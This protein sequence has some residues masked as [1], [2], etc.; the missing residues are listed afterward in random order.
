[1]T[2]APGKMDIRS[3]RLPDLKRIMTESREE[4][5]RAV[6][7]FD[8][9]WKRYSVDFDLMTNLSKPLREKL[10]SNFLIQP[11][12]ID[13]FLESRDGTVKYSFSAHD[14]HLLEG[15]LIPSGKRMTACVSTQVGCSLK[16]SFCATG[17]IK[18]KRN[19]SAGEI[20]D[21]FSLI[22][23]E[24]MRRYD[25][26]L[27]QMVLMGMGE[28]LLNYE[29]VMAAIDNITDGAG[30]GF[31][32]R[33]ITLST[34]GISSMIRRLADDHFRCELAISLHTANED[35]RNIIIPLNRSNPL[36]G[37]SAAIEYFYKKTGT[38]ITYE[39]L[40]LQDFNDQLKD[41]E[42]LA[43]FCRISPCK[44][45][46]IEYNEIPGSPFARSD[47]HRVLQFRDYLEN[48]K[49][50]VTLRKSRGNDIAA[51]CGQLAG[52]YSQPG[53]AVSDESAGSPGE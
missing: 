43:V 29:N 4:P 41:A 25:R 20:F 39:Y 28:P 16:C 1:M 9:L 42:E 26:K 32:P 14:D 44:I 50:V 31:S 7:I 47:H 40:M 18:F 45:N 53:S 6:Q 35:K 22:N 11:L 5:F 33:R 15:V 17:Q 46:L 3:F 51:A 24:A 36:S 13:R 8:W 23:Q 21:Q 37:L 27:S 34:A 12:T 48:K 49:L 30:C 10:N 2:T 19:L 38:R 52:S